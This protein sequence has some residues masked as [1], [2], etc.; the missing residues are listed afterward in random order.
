MII[1]PWG[2]ADCAEAEGGRH[3][4]SDTGWRAHLCEDSMGHAVAATSA[5]FDLT[6][7]VVKKVEIAVTLPQRQP[8]W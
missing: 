1:D 7:L 3:G 4:I 2:G 6:Q 5:G 8:F